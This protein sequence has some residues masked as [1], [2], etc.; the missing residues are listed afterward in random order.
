MSEWI[1]TGP[2]PLFG[3][4]TLSDFLRCGSCR[5]TE[6]HDGY[7]KLL[8]RPRQLFV[9]PVKNYCAWHSAESPSP[10]EPSP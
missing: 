7:G 6:W 10:P 4:R 1:L 9:D 3:N 8:C 2:P 5:R